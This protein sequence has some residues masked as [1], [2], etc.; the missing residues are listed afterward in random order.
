MVHIIFQP[1]EGRTPTSDQADARIFSG[2]L[3]CARTSETGSASCLCLWEVVWRYSVLFFRPARGGGVLVNHFFSDA[4]AFLC[5]RFPGL[6]YR[7]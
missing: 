1:L 2:K 6:S 7:R 3:R 5:T 4:L